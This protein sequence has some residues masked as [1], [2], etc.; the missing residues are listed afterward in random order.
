VAFALLPPD[1]STT[2][3]EHARRLAW[4]VEADAAARAAPGRRCAT[5]GK[6]GVNGEQIERTVGGVSRARRLRLPAVVGLERRLLIDPTAQLDRWSFARHD[7]APGV[8]DR[9]GW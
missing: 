2:V 3:A 6:S 8:I 5:C 7:V 9:E 1:C 4:S